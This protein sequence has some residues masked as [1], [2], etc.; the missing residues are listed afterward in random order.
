MASVC[1]LST[2]VVVYAA[3]W[4]SV[5]DLAAWQATCRAWRAVSRAYDESLWRAAY[6]RAGFVAR[7]ESGVRG[8]ERRTWR[9]SCALQGAMR[10]AWC[11]RLGSGR[12][13][14][15]HH[16][17]LPG[18]PTAL[19]LHVA[20]DRIVLVED[21]E[22]EQTVLALVRCYVVGPSGLT[23]TGRWS[24]NGN[25]LPGTSLAWVPAEPALG[26]EKQANASARRDDD[27]EEEGEGRVWMAMLPWGSF[28]PVILDVASGNVVCTLAAPVEVAAP[29]A[30]LDLSARWL[31]SATPHAHL[32]VWCVRTGA[33]LTQL[34]PSP[35]LLSVALHPHTGHLWMLHDLENRGVQLSR[36]TLPD[37]TLAGI[38][39]ARLPCESHPEATVCQVP[40]DTT[41]DCVLLHYWSGDVSVVRYP[42]PLPRHLPVDRDV[43]TREGEMLAARD[44]TSYASVVSCTG[45]ITLFVALSRRARSTRFIVRT[46]GDT[47]VAVND[48]LLAVLDDTGLRVYDFQPGT[49]FLA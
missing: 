28:C 34:K 10:G 31:V 49:T 36:Q 15:V 7:D 30:T 16:R 35:P 3:S 9:E 17:L 25:N 44:G 27:K 23:L 38:K 41:G 14:G 22:S 46:A 20:R 29:P 21:D 1:G 19:G 43:G 33:L 12:L 39:Y 32:C 26:K 45:A 40:H 6:A 47:L 13:D 2:A 37:L 24:F 18:P 8:L 4:L 5:E 48:R 11:E 42:D